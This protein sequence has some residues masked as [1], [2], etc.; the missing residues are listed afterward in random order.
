MDGIDS[1]CHFSVAKKIGRMLK[2][3]KNVQILM[4]ADSTDLLSNDILRP[5]CY[6]VIQDGRCDSL[7]YLTDMDIQIA[8]NLQR[9]YKAG[10]FSE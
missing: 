1:F 2:E 9:M 6:F 5:D 3:L 8:H 10:L 4:T 7:D